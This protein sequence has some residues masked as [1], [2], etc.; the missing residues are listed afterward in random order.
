MQVNAL[1][2]AL[3]HG[4]MLILLHKEFRPGQAEAV[5]TLLDITYHKQIFPAVFHTGDCRQKCFLHIIAVL[6]FIDH[7]FLILLLILQCCFC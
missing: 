1:S 3:L 6:V 5:N 7:N 2:A 4:K